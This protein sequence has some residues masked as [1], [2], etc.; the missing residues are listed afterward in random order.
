MPVTI[1]CA[2]CGAQFSAVSTRSD[3]RRFCSR[4]CYAYDHAVAPDTQLENK[5]KYQRDWQR[6]W[7]R[8]N[9]EKAKAAS[10]KSY[11]KFK[12]DRKEYAREWRKRNPDLVRQ[13]NEKWND[14]GNAQ[15]KAWRLANKD[16]T[17]AYR[18]KSHHKHIEREH[19]Y[20]RRYR[21]E[22]PHVIR[23]L[24]QRRRAHEKGAEGSYTGNEWRELCRLYNHTCLAC[25]RREPNIKLTPDHVI[26]LSKGG[27]NYITNIQPLCYS[28]NSGKGN[29]TAIDYRN[30][31][32]IVQGSFWEL[33]DDPHS[34]TG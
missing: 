26:P 32:I 6:E 7:R 14:E 4:A 16:R 2:Y 29:R 25:G 8:K 5:R 22:N 33:M 10:K 28:C 3:G 15:R 13:Y 19:A 27:N 18:R 1:I 30:M 34:M 12:E 20:S 24:K 17:N 23:A 9:A 31:P 21:A 11:K